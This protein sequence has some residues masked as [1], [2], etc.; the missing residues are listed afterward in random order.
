MFVETAMIT[1]QEVGQNEAGANASLLHLAVPRI[2]ISIDDY[3]EMDRGAEDG[4]AAAVACLV[5][6]VE[7]RNLLRDCIS[8]LLLKYRGVSVKGCVSLE[9][10]LFDSASRNLDLV[11]LGAANKPRQAALD[12]IAKLREIGHSCRLIILTDSCDPGFVADA[13]RLGAQGI[14]TTSSTADVAVEAFR[15]V[16]A[17][18]TFI[19][20]EGLAATARP[21]MAN[22]KAHGQLTAREE[23]IITLL[24]CGKPNKQIA[25][26]L[27]LS[28]GTVKVHLHNIMKKCGVANRTQIIALPSL[29]KVES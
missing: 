1:L 10:L 5:A 27:G 21:G 7:S 22:G 4:K 15:L 17:G 14:L 19:P 24:R 29:P 25:R 18:G 13:L 2:P 16:M 9:E 8:Y 20:A 11:I 12:E 23:Q 3:S 26:E 6:V 28:E